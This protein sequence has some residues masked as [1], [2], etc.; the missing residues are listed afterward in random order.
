LK[1]TF[2]LRWCFVA[3]AEQQRARLVLLENAYNKTCKLTS[4]LDRAVKGYQIDVSSMADGLWP[5]FL[6]SYPRQELTWL[7]N[8]YKE[9]VRVE[10]WYAG[11]CLQ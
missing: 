9:E 5:T 8:A 4:N 7:E 1:G 2:E 10:P 11:S 6:G 3:G